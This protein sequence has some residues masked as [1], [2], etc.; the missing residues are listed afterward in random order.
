MLFVGAFCF[1][2]EVVLHFL[3][4]VGWWFLLG[5]V[6]VFGHAAVGVGWGLLGWRG[7]GLLGWRGGE[8]GFGF[9]RAFA[10][11]LD[12]SVYIYLRS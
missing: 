8:C 5:S 1:I 12:L 3:G 2:F 4:C 9:A 11:A 6:V 7:W 10:I